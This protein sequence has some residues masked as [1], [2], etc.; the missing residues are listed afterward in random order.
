M[1]LYFTLKNFVLKYV[2]RTES[3]HVFGIQIKT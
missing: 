3:Y 1:H 2:Y